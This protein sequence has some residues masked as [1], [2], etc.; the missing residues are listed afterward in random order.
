MSGKIAVQFD[1]YI[2]DYKTNAYKSIGATAAP[3]AK[4][5]YSYGKVLD[6]TAKMD[7][8]LG[9]INSVG[10]EDIQTKLVTVNEARKTLKDLAKGRV[11]KEKNRG[12]F[13]NWCCRFGN[14]IIGRGWATSGERGVELAKNM[15]T[16][17]EDKLHLMRGENVDLL[18]MTQKIQMRDNL[19]TIGCGPQVDPS[20]PTAYNAHFSI[21]GKAVFATVDAEGN[22]A[23]FNRNAKSAAEYLPLNNYIDDN[24]CNALKVTLLENPNDFQR[25]LENTIKA[26]DGLRQ[27]LG[28]V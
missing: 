24:A 12:D 15:K 13:V 26:N 9:K 11:E 22:V 18:S 28:I 7:D 19:V 8:V 2:T 1:Q 25:E 6:L 3:G 5:A 14:A 17:L 10:N 27:A 20:L 4:P 21:E 16:H 23:L